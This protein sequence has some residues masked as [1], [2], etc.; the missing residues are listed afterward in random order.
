MQNVDKHNREIIPILSRICN[1][2]T[3]HKLEKEWCDI[4]NA[5]LNSN[6]PFTNFNTKSKEYFANYREL[7]KEKINQQ[8][9]KCHKSNIQNKIY[10]CGVCDKPFESNYKLQKHFDTLKHQYRYLNSLD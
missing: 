9:A 3:I 5:D 8:I 2:D 7:N 4:L 6:S 10:H 1:K